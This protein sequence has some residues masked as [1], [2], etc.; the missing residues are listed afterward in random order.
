MLK[1][2]QD[3]HKLHPVAYASRL[4]T[5]A[6]RNYSITELEVLAVVWALTRFHSYLY[7]QSVT[8][9]TDHAAVRAVLET[10]NPSAKHA[11]WWTRVYGTGLKD[12][13]IVYR[14][15]RLNATADTLSRSPHSESPAIG[16]GEHET[17]VPAV[18]STDLDEDSRADR[19]EDLLI[20][21]PRTMIGTSFEEEQMKDPAVAE[22]I[23]FLETEQLPREDKRARRIA[24]QKSLFVREKGM[25]FY[26][27]PKQEHRLRVVVPSHLREQI[28]S[29]HHSGPTGGHFA[30]KKMYG[31]LVR[32]WWWHGMYHDTVQF[33]GRCPQCAIVTGGSRHHRPP[34][35]PIPV[36]RPF[37]IIGVDVMELPTTDR[38]NRYMLVFQDFLTKW[39]LVYAM[40]DQKSLCIV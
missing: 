40:P 24:L 10:P 35:H 4:L 5:A 39:P 25:L 14:P 8:V 33:A 31:A 21:P 36:S 30:A 34:L 17:Q 28:L 26:A 32:R 12:I 2:E 29:E 15:G 20:E 18:Q 11:R 19:I 16:E 22:V 3:D 1:Q 37:Q 27:D 6:E 13:H 7:G 9:V 38:G 23:T